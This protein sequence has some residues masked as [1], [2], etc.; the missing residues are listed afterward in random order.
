MNILICTNT[1]LP[2]VGGV[3]NAVRI[4]AE[5]CV[6]A[7]HDVLVVAPEFPGADDAT[8]PVDVFRVPAIQNFNGSD[9][10]V[11]LPI[12]VY[13]SET[14]RNFQP[15]IVHSHHPFLLGDT[16][17][18]LAA[19]AGCPVVFTHHT[20]YERYTHYVPGH[21]SAM[22]RFA[23]ELAGNYCDLCDRAIAPSESVADILR[24]R[25]VDVPIDA[26]PTGVDTQA[27]ADGDGESVR[28]DCG[29]GR[30]AFVVGYVGRLAPEKNL[31]F[32]AA[33][34]AD[35][36]ASTENTAFLVVGDGP[37]AADIERAFAD[38]GIRNRLHLAGV[39]SDQDLVDA[40]HAMDLFA[41]AS[42]SET[43]GLVLLEA[44]AAGKPVIAVD[45]NGVRDLVDTGRNGILLPRENKE[46]FT[47][48]LCRAHECPAN[49]WQ[50]LV[51]GAGQTAADNDVHTCIERVLK[52][53]DAARAAPRTKSQDADDRWQ[54]VVRLLQREWELCCKH[55]AA[56][57]ESLTATA[58]DRG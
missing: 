30:D 23:I 27:F 17:I 48:G 31:P 26:V 4:L 49:E 20:M 9:F 54:S 32:L 11:V 10:S 18:R 43:Q 57:N 2:H 50:D 52:V 45:A 51:A 1:Y 6:R 42:Q 35:F 13:L 8:G 38:R 55:L 36:V 44:M 19:L 39:R 47:R 15:D 25:G 56:T 58:T 53:Y 21:S 40:Y 29:I 46:A 34:V 5:G 28:D 7:D 33:A 24:E 12:P 37:S 22:K 3:A 16:A 41:F 14:V